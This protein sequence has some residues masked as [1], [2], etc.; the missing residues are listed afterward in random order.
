MKRKTST[1]RVSDYVEFDK[2]LNIGRELLKED[3]TKVFGLYI[4][5][6]ICTGLRIGDIRLLEW[7]QLRSESFTINEGKTGKARTINISDNIKNAVSKF[8]KQT[9]YAF[10]S[11]KGFIFSKQQLNRKLKQV[12]SKEIKKGLNISTHSLRKSFGRRVWENNNESES[13]LILLSDI[14]NHTGIGVT[15]VYLGI[16]KEEIANA[17]LSL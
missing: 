17:Y 9:G 2:A 11:Q 4:I 7:E 15:R 6:S 10:I 8:D 13:A 16:R 1:A 3:K 12:F 14:F 5:V